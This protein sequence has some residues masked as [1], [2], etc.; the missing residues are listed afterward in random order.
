MNIR[1]AA[2]ALLVAS[3]LVVSLGVSPSSQSRIMPIAEV[4]PG[5]VGVGRTVFEGTELSEFKVH[6]IGVLR[7]I[8]GPQR[9]LILAK[10]EGGPL[11]KTGVAAGMSGSPVYVDG[12][13]VGAVGYSIGA[14]PTEAI[15][16]I[17]PIEEMKDA[18]TIR[19]GRAGNPVARVDLPITRES[20]AAALRQSY[21]RLGPFAAR[22]T[23]VQAFGLPA[24]EGGQ[25]ATMLRPIATPLLMTGFEPATVDL[26]TA[27]FKEAGFAPVAG[28]VGGRASDEE[29]AELNG[30]LREG[31]PI[32]VSLVGGD[33][34]MG[35]TG[36]ITHIDGDKVYAFGHPFFNLGPAE[37]PMTRAYVY[38]MLPSLMSSF[39][40]TTMG[41]VI[42]TLQQDRATAIAGTLGKGPATVPMTVTLRSNR[43][44]QTTTRT[45]KFQIGTD[46]TFTPL[47]SYVTLFNTL[48]SYER[49]FGVATFALKG[50]A[51]VKDHQALVFEDIYAGEAPALAAATS[52]GGPL[53]MLLGNDREKLTIESLDFTIDAS[54][55]P[56]S[57]TIERVW[58]DELRPRA[59]R[60]IPLKI[61]TRSYRGDEKISTVDVAIPPN[62]TGTLS[63]VVTDGRQL[64]AIEQ[65]EMRRTLQP[66]S[67][68][69]LIRVLNETRRNNRIYVR[70]MTGAPGA[71]V[72]GEALPALPPSVLSVLEAD[73]NGGSFSP[74]RSAPIGEYEVP[75]DV[76]VVGSRTLAIEVEPRSGG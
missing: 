11:A 35:A 20:L 49:G 1:S 14:F 18:A 70:L 26:V 13:L 5:M 71:V 2:A 21:T 60:T 73:R 37:L 65:R 46:Q 69:H 10:L 76:A 7:N 36:T 43:D 17:T 55:T 15:A 33:L 56:R 52:I 6:I 58:I 47:L 67:A 57:A 59:G 68:A 53:T 32:G 23:D 12:R 41:D 29:R 62:A 40:I 16:G 22:A 45:L 51:K 25:L 30:P 28:G 66:Q 31:D 72:N 3:L 54:E 8:Q 50:T 64:N 42:G 19:S 4:K 24:A 63:V 75:M 34:E 39:K 38:G 27:I 48:A 74:I 9:D 44:G 61:L